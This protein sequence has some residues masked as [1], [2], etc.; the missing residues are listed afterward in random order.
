ML[1]IILLLCILFMFIY[2]L[3]A[4]FFIEINTDIGLYRLRF[5]YLASG[6]VTFRENSLF[7]KV[8]VMFW[9]KEFDM[10][11]NSGKQ[12]KI[13]RNPDSNKAVKKRKISFGKFRDKA[14]GILKSFQVKKCYIIV[15]TGDMP[16]NGI[17]YP[18][19]CLLSRYT[20]RDINI[21]FR[22]ENAV[23]LK[24]KNSIVRVLWAY[25]KS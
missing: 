1:W 11:K 4:P 21:N 23:L 20:G 12:K 15:D 3:T 10:L 14:T 7:M 2:L 8:K 18:W 24:V 13:N 22:G 19:F 17:L 16:L 9:Y 5:H 6:S 25:M